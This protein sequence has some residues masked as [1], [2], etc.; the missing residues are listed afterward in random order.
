MNNPL[1][2]TDPTGYSWWTRN[3]RAILGIVAAAIIGPWV[4]DSV[5]WSLAPTSAN[6]VALGNAAGM[7]AGGFAAG[8]IMG[9]NLESAVAGAFSAALFGMA[10]DITA[11]M[12]SSGADTLGKVVIHASM[13]CLGSGVT[14]GSCEGGAAAAGFSYL[15]G[16]TITS[17]AGGNFAATVALRSVAGGIGARL[18]GGDFAGGL[19]TGAFG[20]LYNECNHGGCTG[21]Y[22]EA[23]A[24]MHGGKSWE[25]MDAG[26]MK[27]QLITLGLAHAGLLTA[28]AALAGGIAGTQYA[29]AA[30]LNGGANT[31]FWSGSPIAAAYASSLGT[32]ISQT[33]I[34]RAMTW[35]DSI[36]RL[37]TSWWNA[38]SRTFASNAQGIPTAVL[39]APRQNA[40]WLTQELP[41][42]SSRGIPVNIQTIVGPKPAR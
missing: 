8:G 17:L 10:G 16:P 9:G 18:G 38:A 2:L 28:P 29:L 23:A 7:L 15:A 42:L 19:I 11:V 6:A 12:G 40:T 14:G 13:G 21:G 20:Y 33:P 3:R 35:A 22:D 24:V 25:E 1:S 4:A 41:V 36:V 37:P 34:G 26:R 27:E 30:G 31:V 32:T 5:M 39:H